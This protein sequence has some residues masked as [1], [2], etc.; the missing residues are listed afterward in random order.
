MQRL[1][2]TARRHPSPLDVAASQRPRNAQ[3]TIWT[4]ICLL[5]AALAVSPTSAEEHWPEFRGPRGDGSALGS[6]PV[7]WSEKENVRWRTAIPGRGWSSPVVWGEKIWLTTATEDGKKMSV[8]CVDRNSGKILI[9]RVIFENEEPRFCHPTNSYASCTPALEE[10]AVYVHFGSYGTACLDPKTA[11]VRWS[12]RDLPCDHFR[13]PGSSPVIDGDLL[14]VAFDGFDVQYVAAL[15]KK[16][17]KTVWR[18]DRNIDYGTDNGDRKKAYSTA[19]V[20]EFG[21][22]R[23]LISPSAMETISYD[24]ATGK[25]L[26]RVKHGGMNAAVRPLFGNGLV[27]VAAGDGA[28]D[29]VA[30]RPDGSGDVTSTHIEWTLGKG[31]PKRPS[32]ILQGGLLYM[33]DDKSVASCIDATNGEVVWQKRLGGGEYRA[34]PVIADG[35]IY[36]FS[37][38]GDAKV[39]EAATQFKLLAENT[40]PDGCQASPA[41]VDDALI[42]R[43]IKHLYCIEK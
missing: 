30:V 6:P 8:L 20:I 26:W 36:C 2:L 14:Y 35:R 13:G 34:S 27:Y 9:N 1:S 22:R 4:A 19:S 3:R 29:M 37:T 10:D 16:T 12:R 43:T 25:E 15:N 40:L 7:S 11:D 18:R 5:F 24:P 21:G 41:V 38:Q 32:Q 42:V 31:V 33:I 17:G 39:I 23:Q 28:R